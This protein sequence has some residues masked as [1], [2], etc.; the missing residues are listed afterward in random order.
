MGIVLF[1]EDFFLFLEEV[2][3]AAFLLVVAEGKRPA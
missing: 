2:E 3:V 1:F